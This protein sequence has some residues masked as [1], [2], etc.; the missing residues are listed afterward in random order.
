VLDPISLAFEDGN[1]TAACEVR[2]P[3]DVEP[4][5]DLDGIASS[6][7]PSSNISKAANSTRRN[8]VAVCVAVRSIIVP[9]LHML[10]TGHQSQVSAVY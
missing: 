2:P 9:R 7:T 3:A 6:V 5:S 4:L 1:S 10:I 8:G